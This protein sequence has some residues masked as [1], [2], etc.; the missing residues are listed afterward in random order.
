LRAI[1]TVIKQVVSEA[2]EFAKTAPVPDPGESI[3]DVYLD[4]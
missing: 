3:T 2:A 4:A 1:D